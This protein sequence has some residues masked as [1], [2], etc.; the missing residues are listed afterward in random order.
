MNPYSVSSI[1]A[2]KLL[3]LSEQ[4]DLT[5]KTN[6]ENIANGHK[7]DKSS[8]P[9]PYD[10]IIDSVK[11][12]NKSSNSSKDKLMAIKDKMDAEND[13]L[14]SVDEKTLAACDML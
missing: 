12:N 3:S 5:A 10:A 4:M 9:N 11:A 6:A 8:E 7:N 2:H 13:A 1:L 14:N